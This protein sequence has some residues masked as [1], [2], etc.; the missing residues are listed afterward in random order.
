MTERHIIAQ[1]I[2]A[3]WINAGLDVHISSPCRDC[4]TIA[5]QTVI[6]GNMC[7][8]KLENTVRVT[9]NRFRRVD[10]GI[11]AVESK[12]NDTFVIGIEVEATNAL[13]YDRWNDFIEAGVSIFEVEAYVI[14]EA[15]KTGDLHLVID[16]SATTKLCDPCNN[17]RIMRQTFGK[18]VAT[19]I[20]SRRNMILQSIATRER[21]ARTD[22]RFAFRKIIYHRGLT[23]KSWIIR[24]IRTRMKMRIQLRKT[25]KRWDSGKE[26]CYLRV[27]FAMKGEAKRMGAKWDIDAKSWYALCHTWRRCVRWIP[28]IARNTDLIKDP[29]YFSRNIYPCVECEDWIPASHLTKLTNGWWNQYTE[30]E[31]QYVCPRCEFKC[32]TC[33]DAITKTQYYRYL[34]RCALCNISRKRKREETGEPK[35]DSLKYEEDDAESDSDSNEKS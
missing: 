11:H 33:S 18:M 5:T 6:H 27:P 35:Y 24:K 26:L 15:F 2:I 9:K 8:A 19:F 29:P 34:N 22:I 20:Q 25:L 4:R 21:K 32:S 16:S 12:T 30:Y 31:N 13:S 10:V 17:I 14:I 28:C 3:S 7:C 1:N 23:F